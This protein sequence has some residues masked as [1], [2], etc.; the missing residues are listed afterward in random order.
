MIAVTHGGIETGERL[1]LVAD[2]RQRRVEH[3]AYV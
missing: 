3:A 1:M 2:L